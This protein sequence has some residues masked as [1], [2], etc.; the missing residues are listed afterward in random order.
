MFLGMS[1]VRASSRVGFDFR[2]EIE[3]IEYPSFGRPV[4]RSFARLIRRAVSDASIARADRTR[5]RVSDAGFFGTVCPFALFTTPPPSPFTKDFI[6]RTE[7]HE[8]I[9]SRQF[10]CTHP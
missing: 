1:R 10:F 5:C 3:T 6:S 9:A 7:R 2:A 8:K 4:V